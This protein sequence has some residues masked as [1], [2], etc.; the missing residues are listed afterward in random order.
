M[1]S[2]ASGYFCWP[3]FP[4][5]LITVETCAERCALTVERVKCETFCLRLS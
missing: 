5:M 2:G 3:S 1:N 4:V